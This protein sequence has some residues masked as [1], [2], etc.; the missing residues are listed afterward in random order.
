HARRGKQGKRSHDNDHSGL[1][2]IV[3]LLLLLILI[4]AVIVLLVSSLKASKDSVTETES[5]QTEDVSEVPT[6][7]DG[8]TSIEQDADSQTVSDGTAAT[9]ET[10]TTDTGETAAPADTATTQAGTDT[11]GTDTDA[12]NSGA[13]TANT[14]TAAANTDANANEGENAQAGQT[15]TD[16]QSAEQGGTATDVTMR[17]SWGGELNP[18]TDGSEYDYDIS[19][20]IG[21]SIEVLYET[22]PANAQGSAVWEVSD[23]SVAVVLQN[24]KVT[25][26]STGSTVLKLTVGDATS[27][28][29]IHVS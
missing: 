7:D 16:A 19:L 22:Q 13:D 15:G 5:T 6:Q 27:T 17:T 28:C 21:E 26:I 3:G 20:G 4:V 2:V 14:D 23:D 12:A 1:K 29:I 24:G 10:A 11:S 18:Y 8:V 9:G 25:G